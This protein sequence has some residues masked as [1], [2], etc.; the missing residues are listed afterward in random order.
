MK[1]TEKDLIETMQALGFKTEGKYFNKCVEELLLE[2]IKLMSEIEHD[3]KEYFKKE[4]E[5][6]LKPTN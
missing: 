4:L 1:P 5:R 3:N 2:H 6:I